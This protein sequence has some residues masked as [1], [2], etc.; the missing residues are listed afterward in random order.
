MVG[1]LHAARIFCH[2]AFYMMTPWTA[3]VVYMMTVKD[4]LGNKEE[5]GAWVNLGVSFTR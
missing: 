4:M 2:T 1:L 5:K 3:A